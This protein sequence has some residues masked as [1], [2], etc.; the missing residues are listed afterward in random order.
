MAPVYK[1]VTL[2]WHGTKYTIKPTLELINEIENKFSLS[3]V[4]SRIAAGDPPIS[5]IATMVGT[6]LRYAGAQVSDDE[7]YAELLAGEDAEAVGE[8]ATALMTA[9]FPSAAVQEGKEKGNGSPGK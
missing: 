1:T 3:R 5:H 9:A 4:V 7:V 6:M 2:E 8:M